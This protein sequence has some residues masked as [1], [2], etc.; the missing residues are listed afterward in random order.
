MS[1]F[2]LNSLEGG[3][4]R[5]SFS[6]PNIADLVA[7]YRADSLVSTAIDPGSLSPV[8]RYRA[9][10]GI[11]LNGSKVSA[12]ADS[13]SG[14]THNLTQVTGSKQPTFNASDAAY[15]NQPS[16]A[17]DSASF[18]WLTSATWAS[19]IAA[20]F[21][22]VV[23]GNDDGTAAIQ[24]YTDAEVG[25][26]ETGIIYNNSGAYDWYSGTVRH[27]AVVASS[28]P[29]VIAA[30]FGTS[31][32]IW[33]NSNSTN[34][35]ANS[36]TNALTGLTLGNSSSGDN[37]LNGKM[38]E[39]IVFNRALTQAE[40]NG[41]QAYATTRYGI[42]TK[43]NSWTDQ[44]TPHD[45]T[46]DVVQTVYSKMPTLTT[47]SSY[48][49]Q[50][51]LS[52]VA[53]S[54]QEIGSSTWSTLISNPFTIIAAYNSD[55]GSNQE[56][57]AFGYNAGVNE[58]ELNATDGTGGTPSLYN[59][60]FLQNAASPDANKH[61]TVGIFGTS[62]AIYDNAK[63]VKASGSTGNAGMKDIN[64][65]SVSG[66]AGGGGNLNGKIAEVII[67]SRALTQAEVNQVITYLGN[68]YGILIS[69]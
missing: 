7:W 22:I 49:N 18:Q 15:N 41:I 44:A 35:T 19:S 36:G 48:N 25:G 38:V 6:P 5:G 33:V 21:S 26:S 11:T 63:T 50:P 68:R 47:D 40:V 62:G 32:S 24:Q 67:Y 42:N 9:D 2:R 29:K 69:Q 43:I 51:T 64:L 28:S 20:P 45:S 56:L 23:I 34:A 14:G 30:N 52:F 60:T 37:E 65:G 57:V 4:R 1:T 54:L 66:A 55:G 27:S 46:H 58:Y 39:L 8:V 17:F 61:A 31:G 59:G 16:V 12:W 53:A 10:T 13:I 3:F